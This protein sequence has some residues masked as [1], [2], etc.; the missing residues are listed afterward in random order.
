[1]KGGASMECIYHV[2]T[3]LRGRNYPIISQC[4]KT[5]R[6]KTGQ[7]EK[8]VVGGQWDNVKL[9]IEYL[10]DGKTDGMEV[11]ASWINRERGRA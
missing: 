11:L 2:Y 7:Y 1:M 8:R 10:K 9:I 4:Y 6:A 5:K 3:F